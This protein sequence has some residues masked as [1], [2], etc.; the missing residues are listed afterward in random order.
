MKYCIYI[1]TI[2]WMVEL[3]FNDK[4]EQPDCFALNTFTPGWL[5]P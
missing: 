2:K 5:E 3:D 4:G 1:Y